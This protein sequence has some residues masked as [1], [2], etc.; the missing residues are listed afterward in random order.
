[1]S[2]IP[3]NLK[4]NEAELFKA[5]S[6][7]TKGQLDNIIWGKKTKTRGLIKNTGTKNG[8]GVINWV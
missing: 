6:E 7:V 2:C 8:N 1:V 3:G 4:K 5:L